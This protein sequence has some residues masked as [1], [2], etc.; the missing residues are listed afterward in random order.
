VRGMT[1]QLKM[2]MIIIL[3]FDK[4]FFHDESFDLL[5]LIK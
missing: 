3:T 4:T 1:N 5:L 2:I